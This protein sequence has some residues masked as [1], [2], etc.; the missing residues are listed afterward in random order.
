MTPGRSSKRNGR[1]A[2]SARSGASARKRPDAGATRRAVGPSATTLSWSLSWRLA[3][4]IVMGT[5]AFWLLLGYARP[6]PVVLVPV[7]VGIFSTVVAR[8]RTEALV[9]VIASTV[10]G[11]ALSYASYES[12][13]VLDLLNHMPVYA[14]Q[15]VVTSLYRDVVL[16]LMVNNPVNT[17]LGGAA[18]GFALVAVEAVVGA[19]MVL[20]LFQIPTVWPRLK[21]TSVR[22]VSAYVCVGLL[23]ASF[24]FTAWSVTPNLRQTLSTDPVAE[25]YAFDPVTYLK[26]YYGM[27]E[28]KSYYDAIIPPPSATPVSAKVRAGSWTVSSTGIGA[29][30]RGPS[31]NPRSS[32][33]GASS[34]LGAA[35]RYWGRRSCSRPPCSCSPL[36]RCSARFW[37]RGSCC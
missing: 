17:G 8:E 3:V 29:D 11:M 19:G 9:V 18:G 14:N 37:Q 27:L 35:P 30:L 34:R 5:L 22:S 24:V 2:K 28:G 15:D 12:A 21:A 6:W 32:T 4:Q 16:P 23:A 33:C 7:V 20:A 26:V 10:A 25:Q 1:S 36:S 13:V 31:A